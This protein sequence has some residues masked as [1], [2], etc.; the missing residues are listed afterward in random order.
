MAQ[1]WK[2]RYRNPATLAVLA[3]IYAFIFAVMASRTLMTL[4]IYGGALYLC[5][6]ATLHFIE[7]YQR[8]GYAD[9]NRGGRRARLVLS[10]AVTLLS[11]AVVLILPSSVP[12][13][14]LW[15]VFALVACMVSGRVTGQRLN[16]LSLQR[17]MPEKAYVLLLVSFHLLT[18]GVMLWVFLWNV[19]GM[20]GWELFGGYAVCDAL[21][22]YALLRERWY[23]RDLTRSGEPEETQE[24]T[25][26][27]RSS[28]TMIA[29]ESILVFLQAA[30]VIAMILSYS[31]LALTAQEMLITMTLAALGTLLPMELGFLII[32]QV[33][34]KRKPDATVMLLIGLFL[35]LYGLFLFSRELRATGLNMAN[36]YAA[37][38]ICAVGSAYCVSSLSYMA[39]IAAQVVRLTDAEPA[40]LRR[41]QARDTEIAMLLGEV[42]SLAALA[43]LGFMSSQFPSD[44]AQLASR[45]QPILILPP[46]AMVLVSLLSAL[47]F[48]VNSP[49]AE[50]LARLLQLQEEGQQNAALER[51]VRQ[52]VLEPHR[53]PFGTNLIKALIRPFYRHKLRHPENARLDDSNP[54]ILLCNHGEFYGPL[55]CEVFLPMRVRP[56]VISEIT[57]DWQEAADYTYQYTISPIRWLPDGAKRKIAAWVGKAAVWCMRQVESIPVYRNHPSQLMKT[58]R[59]SVEGLQAGDNLLIFPEN[60]DAEPDHPG[61][62]DGEI[63]EFYN[64]FTLLATVYHSRTGKCA[65]FLPVYAHKKSHTISFGTE[66][67]YD[68][69]NDREAETQRIADEAYRQ[70]CA[71]REQEEQIWAAAQGRS[72]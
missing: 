18:L 43:L 8:S 13:P 52:A 61:Y 41:V 35:W 37:M 31:F 53:Q 36:V 69:E 57:L 58:F 27:L 21:G 44:P 26:T 71:L 11:A 64:G 47:R 38:G 49:Y 29:Y 72:R 20:E 32:R 17:A 68:P 28:S 34:K 2:G 24:A 5:G 60:P 33:E 66:I 22:I 42:L 30:M 51:Q 25:R 70:M 4:P 67:R 48:P 12:S 15:M 7:I 50:K 9:L 3:E 56:W 40:E 19:G 54:L 16:S 59:Q 14:H 45:I 39:E 62:K 23:R 6:Q 65:R 1:L 10:A 55:V 63:G 46:L